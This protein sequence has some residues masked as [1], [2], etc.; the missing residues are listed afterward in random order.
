MAQ[1][2][3]FYKHLSA[4]GE[5]SK[6]QPFQYIEENRHFLIGGEILDLVKFDP[7][8]YVPDELG[9]DYEGILPE[10]MPDHPALIRGFGPIIGGPKLHTWVLSNRE[11]VREVHKV[12]IDA[13]QILDPDLPK[14]VLK[15]SGSHMS[16]DSYLDSYDHLT[17]ITFGNCACMG[18]D[19]DGTFI[20]GNE[21]GFSEYVL[22]NADLR[23]QRSSLY[24]GFGH[25]ARLASLP[26]Q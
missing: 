7:Y 20:E 16:F 13:Y 2:P 12:I 19:P 24:A 23:A 21:A 5:R 11:A 17:L 14:S 1:L 4:K 22:H 6:A 15:R 18:P 9:I 10:E 8:T 25:I 3:E 26:A